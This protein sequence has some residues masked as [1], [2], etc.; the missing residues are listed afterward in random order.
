MEGYPPLSWLNNI[1]LCICSTSFLFI[2]SLMGTWVVFISWLLGTMQPSPWERIYSAEILFSFLGYIRRSGISRLYNTSIFNFLRKFRTVYYSGCTSLHSHQWYMK[3]PF[4]WHPSQHLL[5]FAFDDSHYD[6][7]LVI[8][9][10]GFHYHFSDQW[11][12]S[13]HVSV[14]HF[15]VLFASCS[16]AYFLIALFLCVWWRWLNSLYILNVNSLSDIWFEKIV[17]H[18][19]SY[20]FI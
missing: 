17:S 6:R 1:P 10:C 8:S 19:V 15:D 2:H 16:L 5:F 14:D 20:L 3:I 4:S 7:R 13:F 9:R 11:W 18:S 12:A